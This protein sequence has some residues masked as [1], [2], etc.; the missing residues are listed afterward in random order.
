M[1]D[2]LSVVG[3]AANIASTVIS[4]LKRKQDNRERRQQFTRALVRQ[5]SSE[6]YNAVIVAGSWRAWGYET[7]SNHCFEGKQ[8][9]LFVA[10][11]DRVMIVENRGD[12][13][14]ENW[15]LCGSNWVRWGKIVKFHPNWNSKTMG[16]PYEVRHPNDFPGWPD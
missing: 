3:L 15:A 9:T 11:K 8:Y 7:T 13:G 16:T 4:T 2:I 10:P 12:G 14:F 1:A 6:G 5:L